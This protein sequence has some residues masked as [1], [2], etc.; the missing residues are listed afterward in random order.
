MNETCIHFFR[1]LFEIQ[2]SDFVQTEA[3][4]PDTDGNTPSAYQCYSYLPDPI[5]TIGDDIIA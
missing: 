1:W 2:H 5:T 3:L 4:T